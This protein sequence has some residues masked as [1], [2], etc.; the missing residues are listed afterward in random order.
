MD[1]LEMKTARISQENIEKIR[2]LFPNAVTEV[3]KDGKVE[4]AVDFDVLKQELS[5]S[6]IEAGQERY[7]MT[8]PD[9]KKSI[10]LANSAISATL[11]PCREESV[12]FDT[13]Q[14]LYIEGD[15]LD[16]LKL[17]RETYLGKVKMI[18]IDPPYN[19]GKNYI[20]KNDFSIEK[21]YFYNLDSQYDNE[22]NRLVLNLCTN[23]RFHT[24]WLNMMYCRLK[25]ARDLLS[26]EG[27]L[28]VAID[29][30]ELATLM[31]ILKEL[32]GE[33]SYE[34]SI[35]SVIHN[36]RGQ[37]GINFSYVNEYAILVYPNNGR[38]YLGDVKKKEI[39]A[40]GLRDSGTESDRT[41]ARSCFYP[42]IVKDNKIISIGDVPDNSYHPGHSNIFREDGTVE[43]WP[44]DE[45]GREKKWRY[46]RQSIESILGKLS[47]KGGRN[48]LQV[49]FN[50]DMETM[51]SV[52]DSSKYDA[53]EYGTKV[54]QNLLG[55][56]NGFSY[57]KS[58]WLVH[59]M[60]KV[61]SENDKS[62]IILDFF[63]GSAT[64]AHAVMQLNAE[65]GGSRKFIMVQLPEKCDEKSE[66]YKAGYKNI[67]EIGKERIR[68][69]GKKIKEEL[70]KQ[71]EL[72]NS[73]LG[74]T[75]GAKINGK[76]VKSAG[77][78]EIG[79]TERKDF[80]LIDENGENSERQTM[81]PLAEKDKYK[82]NPDLL[83]I[84]FRVLK[85]D[86]SNM[87]DVYYNP[88]AMTQTL[89]DTTIDNVKSDRTPLD[90]LLQ[91]MLELGVQL[92]AKIEEKKVNGKTYYAVN[93]ND[94]IACFDENLDNDVI[95]EIAKQQPL[96]A[97][98]KDKSFATDSVGINNEQLFKTYS[99]ATEVKVI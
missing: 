83:D 92:S 76:T 9:K 23:G 15:N 88:S 42:F 40:R 74:A 54:V 69:A 2:G 55:V 77:Q 30:N 28:I 37:Q 21:N 68:R 57:P 44:I 94:I 48:S 6:L 26:K 47:V 81:S 91:V 58:L 36:P 78:L 96:Y 66:A 38:K 22:G 61:A 24:D 75:L 73:T 19:T 62:S 89:L 17:L 29:E 79:T 85:L 86:S 5:D 71:K 90:L 80:E 64:T 33:I 93:D 70:A 3:I 51:R 7:Q 25:V 63:S 53:S 52:W 31:I 13:T 41:D 84:G 65:D 60:I 45:S 4:L 49:I 34:F 67:C 27:V 18:Y 43:I 32:F 1:K 46:A 98:F 10:L 59:D 82:F 12:D 8:W 95:T 14:N 11:R 56:Q 20:Y 16:V 97:V 50:K 39:D 72:Y 99:P 35:V 87:Q